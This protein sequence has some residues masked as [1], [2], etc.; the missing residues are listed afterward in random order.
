MLLD[1][2]TNQ[3]SYSCS[4]RF[5]CE[6]KNLLL[7]LANF[8]YKM[9]SRSFDSV[10]RV[11][12]INHSPPPSRHYPGTPPPHP[13]THLREGIHQKA[14]VATCFRGNQIDLYRQNAKFV[15]QNVSDRENFMK[16]MQ[17]NNI[18]KDGTKRCHLFEI[19]NLCSSFEAIAT[20][21]FLD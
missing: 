1:H 11:M 21:H 5:S 2:M 3:F 17:C 10:S 20:A 19:N 7:K 18:Y 15:H 9:W 8:G 4:S 6:G 12:R 14:I 16:I 13:A